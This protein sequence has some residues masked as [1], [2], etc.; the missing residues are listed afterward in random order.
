MLVST[1]QVS[2]LGVIILTIL[3]SAPL[4][5]EAAATIVWTF[6]GPGA[7][8]RMQGGFETSRP[9][10]EGQRIPRTLDDVRTGRSRYV[11]LASATSMYG[12]W[13]C[14]GTVTY[15]SPQTRQTH[16]LENVVGFVHD[17]GC[18]FN[19]TC[20]NFGG[21]KG[22]FSNQPRPDKMDIAL[23]DFRGWGGDAAMNFIVRNRNSAPRQ[24]QEIAG[25]PSGTGSGTACGGVPRETSAPTTA[26]YSPTDLR[27]QPPGSSQSQPSYSPS[28]VGTP[29]QSAPSY[30]SSPPPSFPAMPPPAA[31]S[32]YSMPQPT[33]VQ[34]LGFSGNLPAPIITSLPRGTTTAASTTSELLDALAFPAALTIPKSSSSTSVNANLTQSTTLTGTIPGVEAAQQNLQQGG[35]PA[36][37]GISTFTSNDLRISLRDETRERSQLFMLLS[38]IGAL[39]SGLIALLPR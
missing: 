16:T 30:P 19:G 25:Q 24:W 34:D 28:P 35:P 21:R 12:K 10:R 23:G 33:L 1:R 14:I 11:S 29:S 2:T 17:T 4:F 36:H 18:A 13:F 9:N 26:T 31:I 3:L 27:D 20:P 15:T 6:Y 7:G 38:Q 32:D 22:V 5:A 37:A 39:L 8:G